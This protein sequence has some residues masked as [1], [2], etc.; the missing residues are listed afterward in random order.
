MSAPR[1]LVDQSDSVTER[2]LISLLR[3]R[4]FEVVTPADGE[5]IVEFARASMPD[6]IVTDLSPTGGDGY[7]VLQALRSD[8]HL[9]DTPVIVLSVRDREED[10]A[11]G[12]DE[13]A[14]DYVVKPFSAIELVARIRRGLVRGGRR[15]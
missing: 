7:W 3:A 12:L 14:D 11:R 4:G 2:F 6:L 1:I 9:A 5:P 8:E 13:G 15:G 10:I